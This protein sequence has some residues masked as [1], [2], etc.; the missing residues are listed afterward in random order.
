M[1]VVSKLGHW[2]RHAAR[3]LSAARFGRLWSGAQGVAA[4][5]KEE[6]SLRGF[7]RQ[8][9]AQISRGLNIFTLAALGF[10]YTFVPILPDDADL[11]NAN[12]VPSVTVLDR[13]GAPI[14]S[15][16][17]LYG[18]AVTVD[19]LPD[20]LVAA[21][22]S[23][24]DRRFYSH[25]GV[26]L[27]GLARALVTNVK[28]QAFVEGGSTITQQLAKNLFLSSQR[29]IDRKLREAIL[30]IWIEGRYSKDEIL[31]LYFNR[32]YLGAGAYGVEAAARHYF[33]KSARDVTLAEAAMLAGL[34]QAPSRYQPTR[35][36]DAA[37]TRAS[38]VLD[39]LV[40]SGELSRYAVSEAKAF[41]ATPVER[42]ADGELGYFFDYVSNRAIRIAPD[43]QRD[44]MVYTTIDE[45]LQNYAEAAVVDAFR[46]ASADLAETEAALIAFDTDGGVLAMIGGRAY[47]HSQFNRAVQAKRQAGSAFKPFIYTAGIERGLTPRSKYIDGPIQIENWSPSNYT[48][49]FI[50]EVRLAEAVAKSINTVAVQVSEEVGRDAVIQTAH[51]LGVNSELTEHP[52]L[53]LGASGVTLMELTSA[54]IPFATGGLKPQPHTITRITDRWGEVL[55]EREDR[56]PERVISEDIAASMT[57]MLFQVMHSG[58]GQAARLN[59]RHAAGKTGTTQDWRDAWFVG[60][61]GQM[62]AGVWMGNDDDSPMPEITG[63][64]MPAR[65]W[66]DFMLS[67]HAGAPA[68]ELRGAYPAVDIETEERLAVFYEELEQAF[69]T[70]IEED[71]GLLGLFRR[72]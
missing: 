62:V 71:T 33:G 14:A 34:P 52:S 31:S 4:Q 51:R 63:G 48:D 60:Y 20:Y 59:E 25:G 27:R 19:D 29:T 66:R 45:T 18:E 8:R 69:E 39:N 67:A 15:R 9:L 11:W 70:V 53:A 41:P 46:V 7:K 49:E 3:A 32:I 54:Y 23:T 40:E 13:R 24:E 28:S 35:N 42:A 56:R 65:I 16:G 21:F 22:L 36:L 12:R 1:A 10:F 5:V 2:A 61:T 38:H 64:S 37:Q 44:L 47:Q 50:G 30:A 55:Y 57:H 58:T 17:A 43:R 72:N 26:D 6:R 68:I